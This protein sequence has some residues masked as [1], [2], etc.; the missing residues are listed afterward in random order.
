[1]AYLIVL[2]AAVAVLVAFVWS[3]AK[4]AKAEAERYGMDRH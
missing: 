3:I 4:D 2:L 1:M